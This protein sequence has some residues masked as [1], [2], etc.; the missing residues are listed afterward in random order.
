[1]TAADW[2]LPGRPRS[3][4]ADAVEP[5]PARQLREFGCEGVA[6]VGGRVGL[7]VGPAHEEPA[8]GAVGLEVDA[9]DELVAEEEG[10]DVVPEHPLGCG[11]VDLDAVPE[12]EEAF[13][14]GPFPHE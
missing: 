12:A 14:A 11:G 6:R 10:Q 1:S 3:V 4:V 2:G 13:G 8:G 9:R 7:E 5:Q